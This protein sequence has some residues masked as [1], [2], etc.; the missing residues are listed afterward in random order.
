MLARSGCFSGKKQNKTKL[1]NRASA[2]KVKWKKSNWRRAWSSFL[3]VCLMVIFSSFQNWAETCLS[4]GVDR[5]C[6]KGTRYSVSYLFPGV[7]KG[8]SA[9]TLS[10]KAIWCHLLR[11]QHILREEMLVGDAQPIVKFWGR[12]ML[13]WSWVPLWEITFF[14]LWTTLSNHFCWISSPLIQKGNSSRIRRPR[15]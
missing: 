11:W 8:A 7:F 6:W 13:W 9:Q 5:V 3:G 4:L 1:G 10:S 12:Q 2:F 15:P 14:L